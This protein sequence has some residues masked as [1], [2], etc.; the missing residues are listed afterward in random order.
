MSDWEIMAGDCLEV[1]PALPEASARLVF[2]DPPYNIGVDYGEGYDDLLPPDEYNARIRARVEAAARLL[3]P[4]GSLWLLLNH[5]RAYDIAMIVPC[6]EVGLHWR[7]TIVWYE[8]FGVNMN[9]RQRKFS[10]TS[11]Q[12]FWFTKHERKFVF[13]SRAP[14]VRRLSARQLKYKD[15]RANPD[16]KLLDD[17]WFIPR[18]AGTHGERVEG[19]PT[20]LP[21]RL[22]RPIIAVASDPGDLVVDPFCGSGTSGKAAMT[23]GRRY[24][25]VELSAPFAARAR[26][27]IGGLPLAI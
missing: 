12:L 10:R 4:D 7:Q 20:Q 25:G 22:L 9:E 14:E 23:M 2:A 18:V 1:M 19:F 21:L 11:R 5:E 16:G 3:T 15:K 24:V 17:V 8:T 26:E 13:N 6:R 27:R